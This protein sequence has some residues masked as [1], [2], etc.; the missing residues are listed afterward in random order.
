MNEDMISQLEKLQRQY[1]NRGDQ[2]KKIEFQK[3][4]SFLR[5]YNKPFE[6]FDTIEDEMPNV[7]ETVKEKLKEFFRTGKI[8]EETTKETEGSQE[9]ISAGQQESLKI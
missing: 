7:G 2:G 5:N 1:E 8:K 9:R 6:D 4:L 3:A